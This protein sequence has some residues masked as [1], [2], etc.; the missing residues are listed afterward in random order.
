MKIFF[1][2]THPIQGTGYGRVANKITNHLASLP[3]VEVVFYAF[4]NYK[5]QEI[6]DRFIDPRIK[7]YDAVELDPAAPKGF[8][9]AG[10]IPAIVKEKPDVLFLYNDVMVTRSL[11]RLIPPEH[12]PPT[13]VLY[14][15]IVYPFQDI[16]VYD[17]L[18]L[19]K[20][21]RI[22]TFLDFWKDHLVN[23]IGFDPKIVDV[24]PHGVDFERFVDVPQEEA[25]KKLGFEPDDFL[26]LNM[27]RNSMRKDWSIT[28]TAFLKF[29]KRQNMNPKIKLYCGCLP[30]CDDGIDI[31]KVITNE[32]IRLK[33]NPGQVLNKHTFLNPKPLHL[34]DG[35]VNNIYNAADVGMNT[36][37]GEGFGLTT[38]E[39][40]YFNK[41]QLVSGVPALKE[42]IGEHAY[43]IE[44]KI[45]KYAGEE[46]N[47][48]GIIYSCSS[49]DFA[50]GLEH[51][52]KNRDDK[53]NARDYM[54]EKY[55]WKKAYKVLDD[56]FTNGTVPATK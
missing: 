37:R 18:K 21:D 19:Y 16:E 2:C 6:T 11:M 7:F 33:L 56:Y 49:T 8:G 20:F 50:D 12:M 22:W 5:G 26:V 42:T 44:P 23:D 41:P 31:R 3:G 34:S 13:K 53:P 43:I 4:Q 52:F 54:K 48:G 28:I 46:E 14:V 15:D 17:E 55:D 30:R 9:D 36:G 1:M 39:H 29:L 40:I 24:L 25:K 32:C 47:H 45:V 10:I 38:A 35:D 27:N 51:Y